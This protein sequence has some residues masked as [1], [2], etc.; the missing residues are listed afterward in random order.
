MRDLTDNTYTRVNRESAIHLETQPNESIR[1]FSLAVQPLDERFNRIAQSV[2]KT[3]AQLKTFEEKGIRV[4]SI[5][6]RGAINRFNRNYICS[7]EN[8]QIATRSEFPQCFYESIKTN[9]NPVVK[10]KSVV[11]G[12]KFFLLRRSLVNRSL[13]SAGKLPETHKLKLQVIFRNLASNLNFREIR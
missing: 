3:R 11:P 8:N 2:N 4:N 1:S 12:Q 9:S 13:R 7:L 5:N 6:P 10:H